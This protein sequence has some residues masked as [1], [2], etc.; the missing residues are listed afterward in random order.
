MKYFAFYIRCFFHLIPLCKYSSFW[1]KKYAKNEHKWFVADI[2]HEPWA[3][4]REDLF[5]N[6]ANNGSK[7]IISIKRNG[8][9]DNSIICLDSIDASL[10]T[11]LFHF[12]GRKMMREHPIFQ[13]WSD[14]SGNGCDSVDRFL[15]C[16]CFID[17]PSAIHTMSMWR[18]RQQQTEKKIIE[19]ESWQQKHNLI[20]I[21]MNNS[22]SCCEPPANRI[23]H[24][25]TQTTAYKILTT[26]RTL[27]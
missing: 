22:C 15:L 6:M 5:T 12:N 17:F 1:E 16:F 4:R 26:T 21:T 25:W 2:I 7:K 10:D 18:L 14:S 23:W 13:S 8:D 9:L 3:H 20:I 19:H 24:R 27:N 11:F